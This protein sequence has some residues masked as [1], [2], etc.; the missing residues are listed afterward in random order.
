MKKKKIVFLTGTRADFGKIKSLI[1]GFQKKNKFRVSIF[2]TGMHLLKRYGSTINEIKKSGIK[3]IFRFNNQKI[4]ER[5]SSILSNTINGFDNFIKKE[6]PDLIVVHGDRL[7][8]L[9]GATSGI[10]NNILVAHIEGGELS[11][12]VDESLRHARIALDMKPNDFT[13]KLNLA[14]V[15]SR[16]CD[17]SRYPKDLNTLTLSLLTR[18][19]NEIDISAIAA[20]PFQRLHQDTTIEDHREYLRVTKLITQRLRTKQENPNSNAKK[21]LHQ[22]VHRIKKSSQQDL[23]IGFVSGDFKDHVVMRFFMPL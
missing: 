23:H 20:L 19:S 1:L 16:F 8:A 12:T 22:L 3:N 18:A 21:L 13:T 14:P 4:N 15:F 5:M 17:F 6:K 10:F 11:G 2:V 9:A 7:E